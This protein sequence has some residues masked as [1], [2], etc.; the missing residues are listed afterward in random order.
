MPNSGDQ[1]KHLDQVAV[2]HQEDHLVVPALHTTVAIC[3]P[4]SS[5]DILA[6]AAA[7]LAG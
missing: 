6:S 1:P 3:H 7:A 5:V 4:L 2:A